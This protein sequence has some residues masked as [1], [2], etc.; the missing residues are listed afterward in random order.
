MKIIYVE[1][2][3]FNNFVSLNNS[4]VKE[5]KITKKEKKKK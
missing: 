2:P 3:K 1:W 5:L 4:K